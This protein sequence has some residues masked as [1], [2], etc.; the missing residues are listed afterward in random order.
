MTLKEYSKSIKELAAKY[1][2]ALVVSASDDE[3]NS[4]QTVHYAGTLGFFSKNSRSSGGEFV[5]MGSVEESPDD[6]EHFVGEEP[7][8]VCIN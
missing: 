6:Y 7:N 8:A 4:F 2:D 3:G 5:D 1:P